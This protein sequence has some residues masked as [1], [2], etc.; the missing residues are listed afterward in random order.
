MNIQEY[1]DLLDKHDWFYQ[2]SDDMSVYGAGEKAQKKIQTL[3]DTSTVH[4]DLY[5]SF[6]GYKFSGPSYKTA[7]LAKPVRP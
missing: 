2:F 1:Y 6:Q 7:A 3:S 4:R 5:L